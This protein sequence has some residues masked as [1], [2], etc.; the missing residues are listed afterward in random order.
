[1]REALDWAVAFD[2]YLDATEAA[3]AMAAVAL[4]AARLG[5]PVEDER[6]REVLAARPFE[7][8]AGLVEHA[9]RAWD[10]VTAATGSEWHDL[11]ADVGRLP[12][13]LALHEPYRAALAAARDQAV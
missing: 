11:W 7:A 13:V 6:A 2:G 4:I 9:L 3:G 8:G 10:R 12:E 1:M 5:A